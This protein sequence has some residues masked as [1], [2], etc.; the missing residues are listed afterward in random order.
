MRSMTIE[1]ARVSKVLSFCSAN[2]CSFA[3]PS[4][5]DAACSISAVPFPFSSVL[6][7]AQLDFTVTPAVISTLIAIFALHSLETALYIPAPNVT[8]CY[9]RIYDKPLHPA[10]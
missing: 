9:A 6:R 3:Q 10:S 8:S 4:T 5:L 7:N 1:G 2:Q